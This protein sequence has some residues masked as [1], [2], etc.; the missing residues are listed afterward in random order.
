MNR[1]HRHQTIKCVVSLIIAMPTAAWATPSATITFGAYISHQVNVDVDGHNILADQGN[2]PT[3]AV[4]PL[5][6]RNIVIGWRRFEPYSTLKQAGYAYSFDGGASWGTDV[7]PVAPGTERT[8]PV[9]D[10]DSAGHFY[11]Q[12]MAHGATNASSV[13]K[14]EDGG[15]TWS[16][17]VYQFTGDKNWLAI[18]KAGGASDGNLYSTWRTSGSASAD[19][20]YVPKYFIRST[21]GGLSFQEPDQALPIPAFGFGRI[22][23]GPAGEVYLSGVDETVK[24]VNSMA[25]IRGGHYFLKSVNA[26]YPG[27]SPVFT[28]RKVEM[29][30]NVVGFYSPST[31][32]PL[33][34]TGDLQIAADQASGDIYMLAHAQAYAW[35]PGDDPLDVYFVRSGDG[36]DTWS[37]PLRLNDDA[38]SAGAYQWF[39]MLGVAP[40]ARIDAVWYDTRNSTG[41]IPGR[42]SRLYYAYSWDGGLTWS[43]NQPVT[44]VFNTHLPMLLV[45]GEERQGS[46]IG[47]YTQLVSDANGAHVA[48]TATYNGEQDVYYLKVFPD[49]NNNAVSD[50]VDIQQ[51]QSGDTNNNHLPDACENITVIG[52]IDGDNDVDRLDINLLNAARNQ[53]ASGPSDPKDL[54]HNGVI[55]LLDARKQILLCTRPRCAE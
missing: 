31:P 53:S 18:D 35:Q 19:P 41:S 52:D 42:M 54:D 44:P 28:A 10:V 45:N 43:R 46:K 40:N 25:L 11:Y 34:A 23:I 13:F 33:G 48:Y 51:R 9:L 5:D 24:S 30:G 4:N 36:G 50:V 49:C 8:D 6:P 39:P 38:P 21:D 29:G 32:N 37:E 55:N 27:E 12:S 14:S 26:Q 20:N 15:L 2:E 47:D 17:P 1:A 3:I 16:E 22:A 7:L